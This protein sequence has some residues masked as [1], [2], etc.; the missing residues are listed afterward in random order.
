[1]RGEE[2]LQEVARLL[3]EALVVGVN[4]VRI[5]HGKGNG[6]LRSMIRDYLQKQQFVRSFRDEHV[7]RGGSGITVVTLAP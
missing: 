1:M 4:E 7:E 5:L 2:A 6:I 3:D